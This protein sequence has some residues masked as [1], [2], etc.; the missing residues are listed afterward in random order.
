[1]M[2]RARSRLI[3]A[4]ITI[5]TL[6]LAGC[7][8]QQQATEDPR[9]VD[10]LVNVAT[11]QHADGVDRTYTGVVAARVQS[12]LGF[13]VQGKIIERLVDTGQVVKE[14]QPLMRIDPTDLDLAI[15]AREK[16][17]ASAR[18]VAV[19]TAADEARYAVLRKDGWST[20]QRYEQAR[21]A[22][23]SANA[24]LAAARAEAQVA[25]NESG[26]S[27]LLAD[28]DGTVMETLAEPGQVVIAGQI[29]IRLAHAGPREASVDLPETVRPAIGSEA[30]ASLYGE[31]VRVSAHLRQ[32]SDAADLRTRTFEARYV[33]EREGAQAP[34]GATVKLRL[35]GARPAAS[36]QVPLGALDDEGKGPGVWIVDPK[37]FEVT[38]RPVQV[39]LLG[40]EAA[41]VAS[42]VEP[43]EQVVAMGGHYLHQG[44]RVRIADTKA[45]MQ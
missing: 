20:Q 6:G 18:A 25:R 3:A 1:M 38:Y 24:Q 31:T 5:A 2:P 22:L 35:V 32:L 12:N 40:S 15:T 42:G 14:G 26:Y 21:A 27:V 13:R 41:E 45:A 17:V 29:V 10:R 28:A 34:L 11:V 36:V 8:L 44:E 7:K 39:T 16:A 30:E 4:V 37:T 19:Q 9:Q 33:M 23:D 43:G